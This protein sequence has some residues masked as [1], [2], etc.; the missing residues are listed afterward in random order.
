MP[1]RRRPAGPRRAAPGGVHGDLGARAVGAGSRPRGRGPRRSSGS[2]TTVA[3]PGPLRSPGPSSRSPACASRAPPASITPSTTCSRGT[4]GRGR[5]C[6]SAPGSRVPRGPRRRRS[7]GRTSR[8]SAPGAAPPARASRLA[9]GPC[10]LRGGRRCR[11]LRGP[12]ARGP[13][14]GAPVAPP[15]RPA[16]RR[17]RHR[18]HRPDRRGAQGAP[19]GAR[20]RGAV[21]DRAPP[22]LPHRGAR[23]PRLPRRPCGSPPSCAS[24]SPDP[25]G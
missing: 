16:R 12:P 10:A 7:R 9:A 24:R 25:A 5:S 1:G 15:P 20:R 23:G 18:H 2:R 6:G 11:L 4:V 17:R 3:G 19:R 21:P 13:R 14:T 8:D 22:D